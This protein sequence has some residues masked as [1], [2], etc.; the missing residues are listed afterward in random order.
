MRSHIRGI[1]HAVIAVRDLDAARATF[2]RLG[3]TLSPRG[4]HTV[5]SQNHCIMLGSDYL[6]LL[7]VPADLPSRPF[8]G[9]FLDQ[10]EGL[11]VVALATGNMRS[12]RAELRRAGVRVGEAMNLSRPVQ[13][14]EDRRD[15]RFRLLDI[16]SEQVP[17]GRM[18]LC[19]HLTRDLVWRPE[20]QVHANGATGIAAI[21]VLAVDVEP[22][23]Q[24][25][26]KILGAPP[27]EIGEGLLVETGGAPLAIV[28]ASRLAQRLPGV[29][30]TARPKPAMAV[31][32]VRVA[33]RGTAE[34]VL[35]REGLH[36]ARMPDGSVAVG[37]SEA[38]GVAMVFG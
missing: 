33:D 37:A 17:A 25:Y 16:V 12:A 11:A 3:F 10:G 38:H 23:A 36:P 2:S 19:Q 34:Q 31:V 4:F 9:D 13:L 15:A 1:D 5:G 20:L 29:W 35:R 21:A 24:A 8:I 28:D 26:A 22:V 7:W 32:F 27:R 18:F 14:G 30:L 6:E